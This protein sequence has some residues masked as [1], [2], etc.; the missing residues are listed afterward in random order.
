MFTSMPTLTKPFGRCEAMADP[1]AISM[2]RESPSVW[3]VSRWHVS[4]RNDPTVI[5]DVT[6][7][8]VSAVMPSVTLL[9]NAY[10][11]L[12]PLVAS[13]S[14]FYRI[15]RRAVILNRRRCPAYT[16]FNHAVV[17]SLVA[18]LQA[19]VQ[20]GIGAGECG[21]VLGLNGIVESSL[22]GC[23]VAEAIISGKGMSCSI[24]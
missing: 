22:N 8:A 15:S 10:L 13:G 11:L 4:P 18:R 7:T 21:V 5:S 6:V 16:N 3:S 1:D 23:S 24:G 2:C 14:A 9:A 17:A 20:V 19:S 12:W